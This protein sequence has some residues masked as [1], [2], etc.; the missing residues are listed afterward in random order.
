MTPLILK[1]YPQSCSLTWTRPC[2]A[3]CHLRRRDD[4]KRCLN[5]AP[6]VKTG[7]PDGHPDPAERAVRKA[8]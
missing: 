5:I 3:A 2:I 4:V 7:W 6:V 1:R 8:P